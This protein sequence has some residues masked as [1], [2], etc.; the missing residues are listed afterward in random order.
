MS[1]GDWIEDL[2]S[3]TELE[4]KAGLSPLAAGSLCSIG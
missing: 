4:D 1:H 3:R 2:L